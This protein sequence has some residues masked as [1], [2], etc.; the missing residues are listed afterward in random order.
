MTDA[1]KRAGGFALDRRKMVL[2]LGLVAASGI[3]QARLPVAVMPRVQEDRFKAMIPNRVGAFTFNSESGLVLPP[4]DALSERLYDNLVTRSYTGPNGDLVML[5]IAYNNKQDGVLQIH[6]PET[7][8]PAGGYTLSPVAPIDVPMSGP[9]PLPSQVFTANSEA[10]NEVVLYWTRVGDQYPRRW[11]E[12]RWAVAEANLRGVI[13]DGVLA[14]VSTISNNRDSATPML[15]S[16]VRDLH[17]ASGERMRGLL[18]GQ[19]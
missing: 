6:R 18:F 7:C 4:S 10:R 14:R 2:G 12:Q 11:I 5:L 19:I 8:Y 17:R 16:F 9:T 3:A 15:A 1:E 13:P